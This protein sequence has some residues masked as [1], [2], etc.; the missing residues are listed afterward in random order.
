MS[1]ETTRRWPLGR[2]AHRRVP[3]L[4]PLPLTLLV[5]ACLHHATTAL[6]GVCKGEN[7]GRR[8]ALVV[9]SVTP[10]AGDE[11][12]RLQG[13]RFDVTLNLVNPLSLTRCEDR[14]GEASVTVDELPDALAA[15][16]SRARSPEW[17]VDGVRVV[18]ELNPGVFDHNLRFSLPLDGRTGR[19]SLSTF[20][21]VVASG[22]LLPQEPPG[23]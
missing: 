3:L 13:E 21:G 14:H 6:T 22:R 11:L 5:A 4:V 8:L 15:A 17:R 1:T 10:A 2:G 18:V 19:W 12:G 7:V 23:R 16:T 20:A 9:D